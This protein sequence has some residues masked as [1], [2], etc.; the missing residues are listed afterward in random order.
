MHFHVILCNT[1]ALQEKRDNPMTCNASLHTLPSREPPE[2]TLSSSDQAS[3]SL[4]HTG[5]FWQP[6]FSASSFFRDQVQGDERALLEDIPRE[7]GVR[8]SALKKGL[9]VSLRGTVAGSF[10]IKK[11][12]S[13]PC[14]RTSLA[15]STPW[16]L[17]VNTHFPSDPSWAKRRPISAL[18]EANTGHRRTLHPQSLEPRPAGT[19]FN[20]FQSFVQC[21]NRIFEVLFP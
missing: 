8:M 6:I 9:K 13:S 14:G 17:C 18:K 2:D 12:K 20:T 19:N 1:D 15:H 3:P 5:L 7:R 11:K 4:S 16:M 21:H 10:R